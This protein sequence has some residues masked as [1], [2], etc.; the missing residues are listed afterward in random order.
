MSNLRCYICFNETDEEFVC[1]RCGNYYCEECSYTFTIHYQYE[2]GL[3]YWCSDQK[4]KKPL[5]KSEVRE[6][7][8]KYIFDNLD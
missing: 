8:L 4:R 5:I 2:G 7:K 1:D 6:R 3:C